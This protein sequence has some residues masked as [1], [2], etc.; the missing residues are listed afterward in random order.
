MLKKK[1]FKRRGTEPNLDPTAGDGE[2]EGAQPGQREPGPTNWQ[3]QTDN[4]EKPTN[5]QVASN[6]ESHPAAS[7]VNESLQATSSQNQSTNSQIHS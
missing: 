1:K 2:K 7:S 6:E 3:N 4:V 5:S